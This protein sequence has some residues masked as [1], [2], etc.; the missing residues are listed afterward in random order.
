MPFVCLNSY[1]LFEAVTNCEGG[2]VD[3]ES[4]LD[5]EALPEAR[6]RF[7]EALVV[8]ELL[9]DVL[10][11]EALE[12]GAVEVLDFTLQDPIKHHQVRK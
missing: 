1:P 5:P 3:D 7:E 10:D 8:S 2:N 11:G 9:E 12:L 6:H 4:L